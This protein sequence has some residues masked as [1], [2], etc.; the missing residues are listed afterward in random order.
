MDILLQRRHCMSLCNKILLAC[1]FTADLQFHFQIFGLGTSCQYLLD[2]ILVLSSVTDSTGPALS[3]EPDLISSWTCNPAVEYSIK[4]KYPFM[5]KKKPDV[6]YIERLQKIQ[7]IQCRDIAGKQNG[8]G[9]IGRKKL[10]DPSDSVVTLSFS[11]V[12]PHLIQ[13]FC[14]CFLFFFSDVFLKM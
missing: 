1:C 9:C 14:F 13:C 5:L 10:Q 4:K 12:I 2:S 7:F 6:Q 3:S 8:S 11:L